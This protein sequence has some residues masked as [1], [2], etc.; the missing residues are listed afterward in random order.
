MCAGDVLQSGAGGGP[1]SPASAYHQHQAQWERCLADWYP[2][3]HRRTYFLPAVHMN[4]V[5]YHPGQVSGQHVYVTHP[6]VTNRAAGVTALGT[7]EVQDDLATQRV[8]HCLRALADGQG[9]AMFVV[10]SLNFDHYL[11]QLC[12]HSAAATATT[13]TGLF[14]RPQ[15]LKTKGKSVHRG[16]FDLLIIHPQYGLLV[17]ELKSVGDTFSS[18]PSLSGQEESAVARR[19]EKALRQLDK[20]ERVLRHLVSDLQHPPRVRKT[21]LLPNVTRT[22]LL[23]LLASR[24]VLRQVIIRIVI[25]IIIMYIY[26]AP[27]SAQAHLYNQA[28]LAQQ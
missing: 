28:A 27:N 2:D 12:H 6:P 13:T 16:E 8:L 21:L 7:G 4:R 19:V 1:G 3:L 24:P 15:D 10:S 22:Q 17:G 26:M 25:I 11:T 5:N 20:E 18:G 23:T 14:P 9:E